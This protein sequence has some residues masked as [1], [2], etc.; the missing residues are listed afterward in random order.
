M[1]SL[2]DVDRYISNVLTLLFQSLAPSTRRTYNAAVNKLIQ[3]VKSVNI[4]FDLSLGFSPQIILLFIG[5]LWDKSY[6]ISTVRTYMSAVSSMHKFLDLHN[7]PTKN[8]L[9]QKSIVGYANN[10]KSEDS[11][12]PISIDML[13]TIISNLPR[14]TYDVYED[15][16][17]TAAFLLAFCGLLRVSEYTVRPQN[18][19]GHCID[20]NDVDFFPDGMSIY[21]H[22]S[23]TDQEGKGVKLNIPSSNIPQLCPVQAMKE[24]LAFRPVAED[25]SKLPGPLFVHARDKSPLAPGQVNHVLKKSLEGVIPPDLKFS[26]H[27]FRIGGAS[28][29]SSTSLYSEEEV[30]DFGRWTTYQSYTRYCREFPEID[31]P[32]TLNTS[33][34]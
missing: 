34:I 5:F 29:L 31:L 22:S 23:K 21:L 28:Y 20:V 16:L 33:P 27:S 2:S 25:G 24:Y 13:Y 11:R 26:S 30:M 9:V 19:P 4:P 8:F 10:S 7:D 32:N 15:T 18:D 3:F 1:D 6:S 12:Q 17:F 14:V